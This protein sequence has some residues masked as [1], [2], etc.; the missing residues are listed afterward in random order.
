LEIDDPH[1]VAR[2]QKS[3]PDA[4][5]VVA[6]TYLQQV[7]RSA[8]ASGL[9]T[10]QA[11]EV[12]QETFTTFIQK[13]SSFEGRSRVRTWLFGILYNKIAEARRQRTRARRTDDIDNVMENRFDQRGHWARPP[14]AVET[15]FYGA[16][17]R[18][19]LKGCLDDVPFKQRMAFL[20]KEVEGLSTPEICKILDVT[21]TNSGVLLFRVRN[22]LRECLESKGVQPGGRM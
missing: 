20:L 11:E 19:A 14:Q 5:R 7:F 12:T 6:R 9:D 8:R 16:E 4:L 21:P 13:V 17:L 1:F 3:D 10:H 18:K 22:R 2:L 15:L